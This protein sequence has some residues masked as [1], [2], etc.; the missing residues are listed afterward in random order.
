MRNST[1]VHG[2]GDPTAYVP[3]LEAHNAALEASSIAESG[4]LTAEQ[5]RDRYKAALE[6]IVRDHKSARYAGAHLSTCEAAMVIAA[7]ALEGPTVTTPQE[8]Q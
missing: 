3:T 6:R 7:V 8:A 1:T 5:E 2:T 4:R